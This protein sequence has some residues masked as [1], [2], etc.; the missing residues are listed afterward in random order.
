MH[1][2]PEQK[3]CRF[4]CYQ[5]DDSIAHYLRCRALWNLVALPRG[6]LH[7]DMLVRL[8]LGSEHQH[9][10]ENTRLDCLTRIAVMFRLCHHLKDLDIQTYHAH[11]AAVKA[12]RAAL[13]LRESL[14][15]G[16]GA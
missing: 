6:V 5:C 10:G 7:E 11:A 13:R 1:V 14:T 2:V 12:V 9:S 3:T 15:G 4:H 8:G 16:A